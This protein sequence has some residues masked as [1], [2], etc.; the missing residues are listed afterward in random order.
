MVGTVK[1]LNADAIV[2]RPGQSFPD[3][4]DQWLDRLC[5]DL[6]AIG[7]RPNPPVQL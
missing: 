4:I 1:D 2:L 3:Y 6:W 7:P 5:S